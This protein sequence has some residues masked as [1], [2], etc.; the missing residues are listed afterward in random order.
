V[1]AFDDGVSRLFDA[2]KSVTEATRNEALAYVANLH[3]AGGTDIAGALK[4]ALEAQ[5]E[6]TP[7]GVV[8][9]L[10]DGESD[11]K[12]ALDVAAQ[13]SSRVRVYTLGLGTGVQKPLLNRLAKMMRGRFT[14]IP[15]VE[16]LE[17][18]LGD[19]Y[20]SIEAPLWTDLRVSVVGARFDR[21][22]PKKQPDLF[23]KDEMHAV[24]RVHGAGPIQVVVEGLENGKP[25][26]L[27]KTLQLAPTRKTWVGRLWAGMR[28]EDLLEEIALSGERPELKNEAV[29]LALAYGL[30]TPYTSF[31][32]LPERELTDET[33]DVVA[34]A[35]E[36]RARILAA[37]P[38]AVALSRQIMPPGD[39]IL[40]VRAPRDARQVTALFPFGLVLDLAYD[41]GSEQ[42]LTR[43]LVPNTVADGTYEVE[44]VIIERDGTT[45]ID[46]VP[47]EIDSRA[48]DFEVN[49]R[50]VKG[51]LQVDVQSNEALREVRASFEGG[52]VLASPHKRT[53][54]SGVCELKTHDAK[55]L[56]GNFLLPEGPVVL[57]LVVTD[58]A[59]NETVRRISVERTEGGLVAQ[60]I[61]E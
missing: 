47:F 48:P 22:Y 59:R 24:L 54:H 15:D 36:R 29:E 13:A 20:D 16:R 31:L 18:A 39:P 6:D 4:A 3:D 55:S 41:P 61:F 14:F 28:V 49:V 7:Q 8:L 26:K 19:L 17:G 57:R 56:T 30:V 32:A 38:D 33:R 12:A 35:R 23:Y 42:W 11:A 40:R 60:E 10:T 45:R 34:T 43:F 51:R 5:N 53:C 52:A 21:V 27:E 1:I 58:Q 25:R 2:P 50:E 44:V 46:H 37:H 9:F